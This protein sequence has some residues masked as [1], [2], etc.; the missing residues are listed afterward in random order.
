MA[1]GDSTAILSEQSQRIVVV[2]PSWVGDTVMAT[3]VLR[4]LREHRPEAH[5][6]AVC[7]PGLE[8]LLDGCP[9]LDALL[10]CR[11]KGGAGVF[12]LAKAIRAHKPDAVLLLPNSFRAALGTRLSGAAQRL[13]Y[14]RDARGWLLT[15]RVPVAPT[16]QPH[17]TILY[18]RHLAARALGVDDDAIEAQVELHTT[19]AQHQAADALLRDVD[20]PLIV[21]NPGGVRANKR[22]PAESFARVAD[23][24]TCEHGARC[25]VT[26][27]PSERALVEQVVGAAQQ[28]MVN[29]IDRGI[30]LGALKA[31]LKRAS[32]LITN[33]TGPRHIAA[34]LGTPIVSLFGPTDWR[35]T[36]LPDAAEHV[37]T[38]EP[39]LPGEMVADRHVELCAIDRIR[40]SDV[41]AAAT[42]LLGHEQK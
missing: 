24:L 7:R 32:L 25:A 12:R 26:G 14:D 10:A 37:L 30:T 31:V 17:S 5:L 34:A 21:L 18:Y 11:M 36:P 27:S 33:D 16:D 4:A 41:V 8:Q 1:D 23:V 19:D 3:P 15:H 13:G 29:L 28:P 20:Q 42:G 40:V 2:M 35:W 9:W 39:F 6:A 22:W 38:A